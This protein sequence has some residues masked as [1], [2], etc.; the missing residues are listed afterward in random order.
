MLLISGYHSL[1]SIIFSTVE[2]EWNNRTFLDIAY[3]K[4]AYDARIVWPTNVRCR[5]DLKAV[6]GFIFS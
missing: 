1:A 6:N 2:L 4:R 5:F 3:D